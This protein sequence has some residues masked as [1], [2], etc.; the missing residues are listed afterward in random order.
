LPSITK[1]TS[2]SF[3]FTRIVSPSA[4]ARTASKTL[5]KSPPPLL[6]TTITL[7]SARADVG[8][9][10]AAASSSVARRIGIER[11]DMPGIIRQSARAGAGPSARAAATPGSKDALGWRPL[12]R[13]CIAD[14]RRL[15]RWP[16]ARCA[17]PGSFA[18]RQGGVSFGA[19][20]VSTVGPN[21]D[22]S[23]PAGDS[24]SNALAAKTQ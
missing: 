15:R 19:P 11:S 14:I 13:W 20:V 22:A 7:A 4:A 23:G 9:S 5:V 2:T 18:L 12:V 24:A 10:T 17:D 16:G 21:A 6:S 8:P 3:A 1:G